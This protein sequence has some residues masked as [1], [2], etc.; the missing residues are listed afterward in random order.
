MN[1]IFHKLTL[2]KIHLITLLF[3][4]FFASTNALA[5]CGFQA[6]CPNTDYLNFGMGSNSD[7][8]SIEYDNFISSFHT[9]V[10]RTAQGSYKV[11]GETSSND[12]TTELLAPTLINSSNFP[13]LTGTILKAHLGSS[14]VYSSTASGSG[15]QGI[16]LTTTGLFAWGSEGAV[17]HPNL[18]SSTTFQ[19][20]TINGNNQGLPSGVTPTD[21]KMLFVTN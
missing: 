14:S 20:L 13:A 19:K 3:L 7:A 12:G 9:T 10:V 6:T 11:W 5:Q 15:V 2:A 18:T 4:G 17:I 8:A 1:T 16:V 21:V